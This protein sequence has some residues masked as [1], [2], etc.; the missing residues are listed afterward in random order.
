MNRGSRRY[1]TPSNSHQPKTDSMTAFQSV[2][3]L[4]VAITLFACIAGCGGESTQEKFMRM[5]QERAKINADSKAEEEA[6]EDPGTVVAAKSDPKPVPKDAKLASP[7]PVA[8]S[9][10]KS[11][12]PEPGINTVSVRTR[13]V[14]ANSDASDQP[15]S[16]QKRAGFATP[17]ASLDRRDQLLTF[18]RFG[19]QV[20]FVGSSQAISVY[21]VETN[22]VQRQLYN[23]QL[24]PFS[25]AISENGKLL[26]AGGIDGGLK[27]FPIE[28]IDGL[29][30]F[31]QNRLLRDDAAPPRRIYD[32]PVSAIAV[33]DSVGIVATGGADGELKLWSTSDA[34]AMALTG[35]GNGCVDLLS[36]QDDQVLF[37]AHQEGV[38]VWQLGNQDT[39]AAQFSKSPFAQPPTTMVAG[40][41]GDG[42]VVGDASGRVTWWAPEND[43]LVPSSFSAH[44]TA[45]DSIGFADAG[46][47]LVTVARGGDI[48]KWNLPIAAARSFEIVETP[49]F[50]VT[51]P[52]GRYI[53]VPSRGSN[54]DLYSVADGTAVRRHSIGN[55]KLSA[56]EFS[57]DGNLV[58]LA[59]ES[60]R[61]YFQ[62]ESRRPVAYRDL[63][64]STIDRLRRTPD[65]KHFAFTTEAGSV[66]VA[67]FPELDAKASASVVGDLAAINESGSMILISRG[68][69]LRL[70]RASDGQT[71]RSSRINEGTVTSIA[72]DD[73]VAIVGTSN[74]SLHTWS[75]A[76]AEMAPE[77]IPTGVHRGSVIAVGL[78]QAGTVW[79]C[80]ES[81]LAK[82]TRL[83]KQETAGQFQLDPAATSVTIAGGLLFATE[84]N[85]IRIVGEDGK[86]VGTMPIGDQP[87]T[88][89][90]VHAATANLAAC[91]PSGKLFVRLGAN[92]VSKGI[93]LPMPGATSL[94]WSIDGDAVAATNGDRVAIM[95]IQTGVVRSQLL[96][97]SKPKTLIH[98]D[99]DRIHFLDRSSRL[100]SMT[101][102]RVKWEV[103]IG[104]KI[105][106]ADL[107]SDG[108]SLFACTSSGTLIQMDAVTGDQLKRIATGKTDLRA[109]TPIP[110]GQRMAMLAGTNEVLVMDKDG[111]SADFPAPNSPRLRSLD[112][113]DNGQSLVAAN[114]AGQ[115]LSWNLDESNPTPSTIPCDVPARVAFVVGANQL[116]AIAA[117][118]PM[119]SAVSSS[120]QTNIVAQVGNQMADSAVSPDGKFVAISDRS[121]K[122]QL[123]SLVGS[124]NRDL[125][126]DPHAFGALAIHPSAT[127]VAAIGGNQTDDG[128]TLVIWNTVDLKPTQ[129]ATLGRGANLL[130]YS[131]DGSLLA[132]GF[133]DGHI[134]VLEAA[135][136]TRLESLPPIDGL[137]RIAFNGDGSKLV[138]AG[139]GGRVQIEPITSLGRS[140]ASDSG[141]VTLDFCDGG[142]RLL[143]GSMNGAMTLWSRD[144]FSSPQAAFQG[145][146][147][148]IVHSSISTNERYVLCT[149]DDTESSTLVWDLDFSSQPST[150]IKPRMVIRG[151]ARGTSAS[152]TSDSKFVLIGGNDGVVRAWNLDEGREVARFQGHEGPIMDIAPLTEP[153]QFV[154]GGVDRS[155]RTW[156][157]PSSLP[158]PGVEIPRGSLAGTHEVEDL[159]PPEIDDD[160]RMDD[161]DEAARQ[162]LIAGAGT[163]DILDLMKGAA[164]IKDDVRESLAR[165]Q[166]LE[167]SSVV[168]AAKLSSERRRLASAK[169]LLDPSTQ[170]QRL[171]SFADGFTN[172]TFV[173]ETNFKFGLDN[174]Y[175]PVKLLFADRFLYAA[176]P[177][178][179]Q[180]RGQFNKT[181]DDDP[182]SKK[183]D[184][185]DNGALLSWDFKYSGLQAHA[186]STEDLNAQE[187][188]ALRD[189]GG[190]FTVPQMMLFNQDG[191]S[192]QFGTVASW[193]VSH[194][195]SADRQYLAVGSA[196]GQRAE[197]DI[198]KVF[199]IADFANESISPYSKY[200]SFE[201][202]VTAMAFANN[203]PAI[204]FCVRERAVHRLFIADAETLRVQK[205]EE[206][207][208]DRS[209]WDLDNDSNA[210]RRNSDAAAGV[211]SLAF[212]PDDGTLLVHGQ[213]TESLHKLSTWKLTWD[214]SGRL[215]SFDK[216]RRELENK[217]GPFF[218]ET[219]YPS[220][221][222]VAKP[223]ETSNF[224]RVLVRIK[225]GFSLVNIASRKAEQQIDFLTTHHGTPEHAISD[226]GRWIVMGDDNGMAY[227]WDTIEGDRYSLTMTTELENRM[228]ETRARIRDIREKPAHSGPIVGVALSAPDP[229]RDYPAYAAT[230]GEENKIKVWELFPILDPELGLRARN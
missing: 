64:K 136:A 17:D 72:L 96:V 40:H 205:L 100:N 215:A 222:F 204:A 12:S 187:L 207:N 150:Q 214:E 87:P 31:Q 45:I 206:H 129:T 123:I 225:D 145:L 165:V 106:D 144:A 142:K 171:S 60:G 32:G 134:E 160:V 14:P 2:K 180:N 76:D 226:D 182:N 166:S 177:S 102:P 23:P 25:L 127:H 49:S 54:F 58:A 209:Y 28:P 128:N 115:L 83:E 208:H 181:D 223:G 152:F 43:E 107:S 132:V 79:S 168:D 80:D 169:R 74:G 199:D 46:G 53:G 21:G 173:G 88:C 97:P 221:R 39:D 116:F 125:I 220:V 47:S 185:G 24:R 111:V 113:N 13:S 73:S 51:S 135:S 141:I 130:V 147:S 30:R 104:E 44:D 20:A 35:N 105:S 38:S 1:D 117:D 29:D 140:M 85:A 10:N 211:T 81:G 149:Y 108:K 189:S 164:E 75:I 70:V 138:I 8:Q 162:A 131:P 175:R 66:G 84:S 50:V 156:Q 194:G 124:T 55:G 103:S 118:R 34:S 109:L 217:E 99:A 193:A 192:R 167:N 178:A 210:V 184:E 98:W 114:D 6:E 71:T 155:I 37:S 146:A 67:A 137:Q 121:E 101:P 92:G 18:G 196:G 230:I 179:T 126:S 176:R 159:A 203:S 120:T 22:K 224:R 26:A 48:A 201:G 110:D 78:T 82:Q 33:N 213:Y 212:S 119:V 91:D 228:K 15:T 198:L 170:G 154:S 27:V 227:V 148:P 57:G 56:A 163:T 183:I 157:F 190:V 202:V 143:C 9:E 86:T 77:T 52:N 3:K 95:D 158:G 219:G 186:W 36:Y 200:R 218:M 42:L 61:V 188:F 122:V 69:D 93:A 68:S 90:S 151:D 59:A 172:M 216:D 62:D 16:A 195:G 174:G 229:G 89:L 112:A 41:G 133:D 63:S 4:L 139:E 7:E 94:V 197:D 5:A 153:G 11:T 65:G 191:S 161:P 19:K